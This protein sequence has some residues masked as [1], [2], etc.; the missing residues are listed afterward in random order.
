MEGLDLAAAKPIKHTRVDVAA[1]WKFALD[2]YGEGY[3]FAALHPTTFSLTT[4]SNV[5]LFEP[6]GLH[7]R[8]NFTA[9]GYRDLVGVEEKDWPQSPYGGSHLLFPN[10]IFYSAPAEGG[11]R[12]YGVY[13]MF[14]GERPGASFTLMSTYRGADVPEATPDAAFEATHDTIETVVRTEDYSISKDGQRNLEYAPEGF[15]VIYG[16]NEPAL[17][18]N[19]RN[20]AR[21]I[22]MPID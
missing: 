20:I 3:H 19:Q 15:S 12:M 22:G 5:T 18:N 1:N 7:Y 17:Q 2:T 13:R 16:R 8:V 9:V 14:P 4:C 21:A 6:Y 10:T 11:G